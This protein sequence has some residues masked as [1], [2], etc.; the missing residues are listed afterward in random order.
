MKTDTEKIVEDEKLKEGDEP[1]PRKTIPE[2]EISSGSEEKIS[3]IDIYKQVE[4]VYPYLRIIVRPKS[5]DVKDF[6][7]HSKDVESHPFKKEASILE[8]LVRKNP[9]LNDFIGYEHLGYQVTRFTYELENHQ[10]RYE[11]VK[12]MSRENPI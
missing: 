6:L 1:Y 5:E 9:D 8:A 11:A 2:K 4:G 7:F 3:I 10:K 12:K